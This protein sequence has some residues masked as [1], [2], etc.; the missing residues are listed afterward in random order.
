MLYC[1]LRS[2]FNRKLLECRGCHW[3]SLPV[4]IQA[5]FLWLKFYSNSAI[6]GRAASSWLR[7]SPA[8]LLGMARTLVVGLNTSKEEGKS[9]CIVLKPPYCSKSQN[10]LQVWIAQH[11]VSRELALLRSAGSRLAKCYILETF[12]LSFT[13][14]SHINREVDFDFHR[15]LDESISSKSISSK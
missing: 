13:C 14:F 1:V 7:D 6:L 2:K 4:L 12:D 5:G 3:H 15:L 10:R 11:F 8:K 9:C